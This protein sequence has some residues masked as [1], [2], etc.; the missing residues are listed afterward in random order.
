MSSDAGVYVDLGLGWRQVPV[1][2]VLPPF[3]LASSSHTIPLNASYNEVVRLYKVNMHVFQEEAGYRY[4]R[5]KGGC[6]K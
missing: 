6:Y 4:V 3:I 1:T 5:V 2:K